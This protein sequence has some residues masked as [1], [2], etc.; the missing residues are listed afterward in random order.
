MIGEVEEKG[1]PTFGGLNK[2][3]MEVVRNKDKDL[4]K[5]IDNKLVDVDDKL[6]F[7]DKLSYL[8]EAHNIL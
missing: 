7:K 3:L 2:D 6:S 8:I 4:Q 5:Q 1:E